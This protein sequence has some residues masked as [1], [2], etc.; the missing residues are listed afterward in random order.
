MRMILSS[1]LQLIDNDDI[2]R[3]CRIVIA[4][5]HIVV[6]CRD[7]LTTFDFE[8]INLFF[9]FVIRSFNSSKISL[10][11][12][13]S[14]SRILRNDDWEESNSKLLRIMM[15]DW[16]IKEKK[17]FCK[18]KRRLII[19]LIVSSI[20]YREC[21]MLFRR[22]LFSKISS[23][24]RKDSACCFTTFRSL[25]SRDL[26]IWSFI[27]ERSRI[28]TSDRELKTYCNIMNRALI[29]CWLID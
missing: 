26:S 28:T 1:S 20:V 17:K 12:L 29:D 7:R 24:L 4:D 2:Q 14:W 8:Y 13:S 15:K 27:F 9:W 22:L 16:W 18:K 10:I 23:S 21:F 25:S 6:E 19:R 5:F 11:S 3:K